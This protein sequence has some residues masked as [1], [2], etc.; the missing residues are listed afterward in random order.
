MDEEYI[1]ETTGPQTDEA[2]ALAHS[3]TNKAVVDKLSDSSGELKYNGLPL[4]T[5]LTNAEVQAILN[6]L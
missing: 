2:I 5:A 6:N 3:H 4:A 1:L